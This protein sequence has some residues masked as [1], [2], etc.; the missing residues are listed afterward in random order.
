MKNLIF[1]VIL[2]STMANANTIDSVYGAAST[3]NTRL[4]AEV[5]EAIL[6]KF[7]CIDAYG[8]TEVKTIVEIDQ[9][10]QGVRDEYYTTTFKANFHYDYHPN[11]S[12]VTVKSIIWDGSN[13]A[14][15]WTEV[16]SVEGQVYCD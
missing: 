12:V 15:D 5:M 13:P 3:L 10:D 11:S 1:G 8:L 6:T 9:V 16:E 2:I 14:I 7:P 4:R